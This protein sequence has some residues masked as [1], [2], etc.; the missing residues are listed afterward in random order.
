MSQGSINVISGL[1]NLLAVWTI[2]PKVR[3]FVA[4]RR[5]PDNSVIH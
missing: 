3:Q 1:G 5:T 4:G 2:R